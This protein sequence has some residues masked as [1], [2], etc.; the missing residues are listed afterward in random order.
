MS[1][2]KIL[3]DLDGTL[4]LYDKWDGEVG[5][6]I[7]EM[8]DRVRGWLSA[9]WEVVIFTA[10]VG[11]LHLDEAT[12]EEIREAVAQEQKIREW[13]LGNLGQELEVTA[14]K[15]FDVVEVWDDRAVR[16]TRNT[17]TSELHD[18]H[19]ELDRAGITVG[20]L[21]QRTRSLVEKYAE[22][23]EVVQD[24]ELEF[25]AITHY[26]LSS[27]EKT[28]YDVAAV[29]KEE[30]IMVRIGSA[31]RTIPVHDARSLAAQLIRAA[32]EMEDRK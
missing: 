24:N 25:C 27:V 12:G 4:A 6:P 13:L 21:V 8:M 15:T 31:Y 2:N 30:G 32:N 18:A 22:A 10:R 16:V 1:N 11:A 3:V 9:G 26:D 23:C 20:D 19:A 28:K 29:A 17:G 14:V 5:P 7:P